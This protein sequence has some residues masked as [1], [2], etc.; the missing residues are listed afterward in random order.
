MRSC[1][2]MRQDAWK[3][4]TGSKWGWKILLNG[5]VL[6]AII[7]AVVVGLDYVFEAAGIQTWESFREA[8]REAKRSGVDLAI[9][10]GHEAMRMT[11]ASGISA[12]VNYLFQGIVAFGMITTL[13]KCVKGETQGWFSG[14]FGG[15]ARP[16]EMFWLTILMMIK[17]FLWALLLIIPGIIACLRYALAWYV[18]AENPD[19]SAN[20]CIKRSCELMHGRKCH[21][22]VF[23]LSYICWYL[24]VFL[25]VMIMA[26][27]M[28][29]I[30][31]EDAVP[32]LVSILVAGGSVVMTIAIAAFVGIYAAI[33]QA[34]FYR[35]A[36]AEVE[37][38]NGSEA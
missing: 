22:V 31:E 34:V 32:S 38:A 27:C 18:K 25:A 11:L 28:L 20:D 6:Y 12:F 13:L 19:M 21:L 24:L 16:L 10:S 9:A 1:W 36:K 15:F 26:I 30:Q 14:A 3:I 23:G 4:M 2:E 29:G 37:S 5:I 8:Q 7:I 17:V 33:G 35:D